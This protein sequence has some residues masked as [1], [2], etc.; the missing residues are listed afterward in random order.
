MI[1]LDDPRHQADSKLDAVVR[2]LDAACADA[3]PFA[4]Q[5]D[6]PVIIFS[7]LHKGGRDGA[8]DFQ[9]C[10][11]TY[12]AALTYYRALGYHLIE[13]G[14]VEELWENTFKEVVASYPETLRL[15]ADFQRAGRYTRL[16]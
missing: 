5:R 9:R 12:N 6:Q 16:F 4:L 14:D 8:D 7:D 2:A 1:A 11:P 10:E 15:A 3:V 13:L